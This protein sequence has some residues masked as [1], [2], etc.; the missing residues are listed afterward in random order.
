[1]R[2]S[3]WLYI[4]TNKAELNCNKL[5]DV[6]DLEQIQFLSPRS[7]SRIRSHMYRLRGTWKKPKEERILVYWFSITV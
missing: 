3:K 2:C 4:S 7:P 5:I 6:T 1:M